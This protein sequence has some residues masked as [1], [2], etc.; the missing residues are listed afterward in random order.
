MK[1]IMVVIGVAL[2]GV[3]LFWGGAFSVTKMNVE[4]V[5]AG[6][7]QWAGSRF[8]EHAAEYGV[9]FPR[10]DD[11]AEAE[12]LTFLQEQWREASLLESSEYR[13]HRN[14][15]YDANI[16]AVVKNL[17]EN[18]P[19]NLVVLAT[20]NIDPSSLR[21][22]LAEGDMEKRICFDRHFVPPKN[23]PI[24]KKY[25][26]FIYADGRGLIIG[27]DSRNDSTYRHI[28]RE[29]LYGEGITFDFT[30]NLV[31]GLQIKYLTTDGEVIP[32]ND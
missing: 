4:Q 22:R 2:T 19:G 16:W 6:T 17:P 5:A 20:R 10:D 21:T 29:I 7:M 9:A 12:Q 30:T 8:Y 15:Y 23:L 31:N 3:L 32:A 26:V 13:K 27:M 25:A 14:K 1:K 28:Y 24:L 18:P 11:S